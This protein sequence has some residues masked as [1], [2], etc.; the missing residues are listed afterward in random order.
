M[1]YQTTYHAKRHAGDA[2]EKKERNHEGKVPVHRNLWR[3]K[4]PLSHEIKIAKKLA[5]LEDKKLK[6]KHGS[7]LHK[8]NE[9]L[10]ENVG[11]HGFAG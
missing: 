1:R 4:K 9:K 6:E 3:G 5:Y 10:G 8:Y 11:Q 7:S 2:Q